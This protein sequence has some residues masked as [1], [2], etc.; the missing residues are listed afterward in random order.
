MAKDKA[1]ALQRLRSVLDD[2]PS[3]K[4]VQW[5]DPAVTKWKRKARV[6][7][8]WT[9][10]EESQ[11]ATDFAI[12]DYSPELVE[13]NTWPF[14]REDRQLGHARGLCK[15]QALIE[16]IIEQIEEYWPDDK[17]TLAPAANTVGT[18]EAPVASSCVFIVHGHDQGAKDA[19]ARFVERVGLKP[20]ILSEQPS[21]SRTIIEKFEANSN[22]SYAIA[23]LT[24]DDIGGNQDD[25][26]TMRPRARQ[27]VIFELGFFIG[28]LGRDRVCA[29][30][31]GDPEIPSD[32]SGVVY[33]PMD[34]G[35]AWQGKLFKE[36]KTAGFDID[37]NKLYD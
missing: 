27:N 36:L 31:K 3:L 24:G 22:V 7:I 14:Q 11:E 34:E 2:I 5:S 25:D 29:L 8:E 12:V 13:S 23:L 16:S 30:T 35:D 20:V 17:P 18:S 1:K 19:M 4:L 15:A 37:A 10:G 6:A 33:I 21:R 9:F 26:G 32:Y 28:K